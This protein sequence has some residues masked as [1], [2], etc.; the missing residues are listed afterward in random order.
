MYELNCCII[1]SKTKKERKRKNMFLK[2]FL[3]NQ[4]WS[5][6][7]GSVQTLGGRHLRYDHRSFITRSTSRPHRADTRLVWMFE[8]IS[9]SL[10]KNSSGQ[11][12]TTFCIWLVEH[13]SSK[14]CQSE[15]HSQRRT[16]NLLTYK[17]WS[18]TN[19]HSSG[20]KKKRE[21]LISSPAFDMGNETN[22][23]NYQ[24]TQ[25]SPEWSKQ[26]CIIFCV[27]FS[28]TNNYHMCN[29]VCN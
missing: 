20:K 25:K 24:R 28:E 16:E 4:T 13:K 14:P 6:P 19:H 17:C 18:T 3:T 22:R 10:L 26:L 15:N 21:W 5:G 2:E 11:P 23:C 9:R 1:Y 27:F 7:A 29:R 12:D 8:V